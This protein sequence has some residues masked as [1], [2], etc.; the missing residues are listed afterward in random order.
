MIIVIESRDIQI[1]T[2]SSWRIRWGWVWSW[3][4][5][6][7]PGSGCPHQLTDK[8]RLPA[9]WTWGGE[10]GAAFVTHSL[11]AVRQDSGL[12]F[13]RNRHFEVNPGLW[14]LVIWVTTF[15]HLW[16]ELFLG[17]LSLLLWKLHNVVSIQSQAYTECLQPKHKKEEKPNFFYKI[18]RKL[19][20]KI[21]KSKKNYWI[22]NLFKRHKCQHLPL[23]LKS[24]LLGPPS[25]FPIIFH[26][27]VD[28]AVL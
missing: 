13:V 17:G 25:Q 3:C 7:V 12:C 6:D 11:W 24:Y 8:Q 21:T 22:M 20:K 26:I 27:L 15:L 9:L 16:L 14:S 19:Q 10:T 2:C 1:V 5:T 4:C 23:P 28:N 18:S